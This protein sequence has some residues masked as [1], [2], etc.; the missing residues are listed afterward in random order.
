MAHKDWCGKPCS[1][2]TSPCLLDESMPC[3]PDCG[4]LSGD[5]IRNISECSRSGCD[6][7]AGTAGECP[8]CSHE[9]LIYGDSFLQ[10][11]SYIY[12]WSCKKCGTDGKAAY[13]L[14]FVTHYLD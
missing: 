1:D 4:A 3:S 9:E 11:E 12:R 13:S 2:C 6:A 8:V 10:D 7:Y 5:G 14:V